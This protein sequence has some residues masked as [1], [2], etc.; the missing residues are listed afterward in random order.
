MCVFVCV[1]VCV[2]RV[3]HKTR[4]TVVTK[5]S[6]VI[7]SSLLVLEILGESG[8]DVKDSSGRLVSLP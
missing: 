1:C 4:I 5:S 3:S 7:P 8:F 6:I 2:L